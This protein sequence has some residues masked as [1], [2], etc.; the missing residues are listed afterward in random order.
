MK[1]FREEVATWQIGTEVKP[2]NLGATLL[3]SLKGK[4]EEAREELDLET[5]KGD[6][7]AE[8]VLA[9]LGEHFPDLEVLETPALP[10]TFAKPA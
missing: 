7:S 8:V 6:D 5:I 10:G 1:K 3:A 2:L 4:A 9:Y